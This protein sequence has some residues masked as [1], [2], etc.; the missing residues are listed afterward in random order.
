MSKG[1]DFYRI[2]AFSLYNLKTPTSTQEPIG[3]GVIQLTILEEAFF[4]IITMHLVHLLII[5]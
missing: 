2:N 4:L 5:L 1:E 3:A